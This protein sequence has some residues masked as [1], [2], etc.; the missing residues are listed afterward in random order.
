[1]KSRQCSLKQ[2]VK[3]KVT[4]HGKCSR[5]KCMENPYCMQLSDHCIGTLISN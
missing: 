3:V 4:I 5:C 1:M 2:R